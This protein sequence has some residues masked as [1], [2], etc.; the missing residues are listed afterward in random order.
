MTC[1]DDEFLENVEISRNTNEQ[2]QHLETHHPT[3]YDL[4]LAKSTCSI[5]LNGMAEPGLGLGWAW[6]GGAGL[7]WLGPGWG[8]M[9]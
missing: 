9:A 3:E 4:L 1:C 5:D 8:G 2:K 6:A 7:A